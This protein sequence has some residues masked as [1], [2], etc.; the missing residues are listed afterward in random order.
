ML[1][2]GEW[3]LFLFLWRLL[4]SA[5]VGGFSFSLPPPQNLKIKS[6]NFQN[7]LSWS[8]V[9][10]ING[11]VFYSVQRR[12]NYTQTWKKV[13]CRD[14]TKPE[15]DFQSISDFFGIILRVRAE[16]GNLKS[17]W[18]ETSSF[19][20]KQD[21]IIGPPREI[22]V[23]SEANSILISF[24]PP[25]E[26]RSNFSSFDYTIY[27]ENSADK[28]LIMNTVHRFKN[29]K[30]KTT[31]CF[32]IQAR[33]YNREGEKSGIYCAMTTITEG[34]RMLYCILILISVFAILALVFSL[35]MIIRKYLNII[36]SFWQPPLTI[37]SHYA[38]DLNDP[39][40]ITIEEFQNSAGEDPWD[41]ISVTSKAE[42]DKILISFPSEHS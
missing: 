20:A 40:M 22:N 18:T 41:I 42:D 11:P 6:Y 38:E 39:Q 12:L 24:L 8:P 32:R 25:F 26:K 23:T 3:L 15:C 27:W 2:L 1:P 13:N 31:Y 21:T 9:K 17:E 10:G 30:E 34:T 28:S 33:L 37:P 7:V 4:L 5:V 29:L 14:I 36:K 16:E 19:V 35:L